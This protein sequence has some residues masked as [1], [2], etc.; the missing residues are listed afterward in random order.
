MFDIGKDGKDSQK[1]RIR[2]ACMVKDVSPPVV[3]FLWKTHK[4]YVHIPPTRPV[5]DA[6]TGPISRASDLMSQILTPML[7][8][9]HSEVS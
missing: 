8:R 6:T 1:D 2:K 5:C 3:S 7:R 4:D 9:R